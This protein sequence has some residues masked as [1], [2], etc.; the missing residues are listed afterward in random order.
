M[1]KGSIVLVSLLNSVY[2]LIIKF[3]K[4]AAFKKKAIIYMRIFTK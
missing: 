4:N 3:V 1:E 2:P